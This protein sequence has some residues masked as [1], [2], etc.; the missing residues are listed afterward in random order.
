MYDIIKVS[1]Q[2]NI[3]REIMSRKNHI[4]TASGVLRTDKQFSHLKTKQKE[5]INMWLYEEYALLYAKNKLPPDSRYNDEILFKVQDKIEK[6]GIWLPF[7]ELRKFFYSRKNKFRK[8][9]EKA[10]ARENNIFENYSD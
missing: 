7:C 9:F 3:K 6:A 4:I 10:N 1:E 8:R 2:F 5:K